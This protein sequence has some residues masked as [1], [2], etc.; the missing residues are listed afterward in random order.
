LKEGDQGCPRDREAERPPLTSLK[1]A[2]P[3]GRRRRLGRLLCTW[4]RRAVVAAARSPS[5][6]PPLLPPTTL[7]FLLDSPVSFPCSGFG[8]A[9]RM[10]GTERGWPDPSAASHIYPI[11]VA[12]SLGSSGSSCSAWPP[13][14]DGPGC[15]AWGSRWCGS[16]AAYGFAGMGCW[17]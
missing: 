15:D 2:S 17:A 14:Q 4:R 5:L 1:H 6:L 8:S 12:V 9:R 3:D 13:C 16:C 10:A 7:F 11:E